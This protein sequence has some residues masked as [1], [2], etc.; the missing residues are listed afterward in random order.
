[1]QVTSF[2]TGDVIRIIDDIATV[3][4]LQESHGGWVDDMALVW[5]WLHVQYTCMCLLIHDTNHHVVPKSMHATAHSTVSTMLGLI[6]AVRTAHHTYLWYH[7]FIYSRLPR[8][9]MVSSQLD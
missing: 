1:M 5:K 7:V 2:S 8:A 6:S 9:V 3:H 4:N